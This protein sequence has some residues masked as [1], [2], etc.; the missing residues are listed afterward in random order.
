MKV[1]ATYKNA[2]ISA[3]KCRL[4]ANQVRA[5]SVAS[6][7]EQLQYSCKKAS[8]FVGQTL[9]SAIANA[10]NNHG[11]DVDDLSIAEI[12]VNEAPTFK[13]FRARAKGRGARILKKNCHITVSVTD[14]EGK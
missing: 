1:L 13:R 11:C 10:E 12:Y 3:Q 6:A 4:V 9:L 7:V 14:D 8:D 2:R 5:M